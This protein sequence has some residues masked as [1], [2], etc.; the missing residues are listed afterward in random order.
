[1]FFTIQL[2][3]SEHAYVQNRHDTMP[4]FIVQHSMVISSEQE[5]AENNSEGNQDSAHNQTEWT[6]VPTSIKKRR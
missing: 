3:P 5:T 6:E 1:M 2:S 4:T